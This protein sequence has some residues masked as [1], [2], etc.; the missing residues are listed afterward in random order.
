MTRDLPRHR[1]PAFLSAEVGLFD[2]P[3]PPQTNLN[4]FCHVESP[5]QTSFRGLVTYSIPRIDVLV[6]S[7]L[8]DK[9]NVGTDQLVSLVAQLEHH[10]HR[11]PLS[12]AGLPAEV[13]SWRGVRTKVGKLSRT[14]R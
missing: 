8:Q 4:P 9:P 7:V 1:S 10:S 12:S 3:A 5:V 11:D 13:R 6:S 14:H 2:P